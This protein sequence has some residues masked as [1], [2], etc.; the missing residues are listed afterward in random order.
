MLTL[1]SFLTNFTNNYYF[2]KII[3]NVM[4]PRFSIDYKS[5]VLG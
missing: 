3:E 4:Y 1:E 5:E 2:V